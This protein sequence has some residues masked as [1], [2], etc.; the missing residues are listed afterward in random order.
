MFYTDHGISS[1]GRF[2]EKITES[3]QFIKSNVQNAK[4]KKKKKTQT[5][6]VSGPIIFQTLK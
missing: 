2:H 5:D 1:Y 4:K 3:P 6:E